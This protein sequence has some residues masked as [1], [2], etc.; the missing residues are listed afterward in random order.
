MSSR[1]H[2]ER[3]WS[4]EQH[5]RA[6]GRGARGAPRFGEQQQREQ[7]EHFGLVGHE[8]REQAREA[9]RLGAEVG[10]D[11]LVAV[12]RGVALVEHE[13]DDREHGAKPAGQL[14]VAG[15]A[16]RNLRV[17]DLLLGAHE[18]LRHRRLGH[19]ERACDVRRLEPAEQPQR[20]RDLRARRERRVTA[21]E[22]EAEAVV[23]HVALRFGA[24][25]ALVEQR[26][27][28]VTVVAGRLA[29]QPVDGAV[30]GGGGD[31]TARVGRHARCPA[32]SR[33]RSRTPPGPSLRRCRCRRRDGPG[34]RRPGRIPHGRSARGRLVAR[35]Q[36]RPARRWRLVLERTDLD[37]AHAGRRALRRPRER[38]VE[39]GQ[40]EDPEAAELFLR[41]SANGPSVMT[42]SPSVGAHDGR[43]ARL[44]QTAAEHPQ[45]LGHELGVERVDLLERLLHH[46]GIVGHRGIRGCATRRGGTASW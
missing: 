4:G 13:V 46:F 5:D 45:A 34:W 22:D 33:S 20:E 23:F 37:R 15:N 3:S 19:E 10:A 7:S 8:L 43:G 26:G 11:E 30:A 27:L 39:V 17:A 32:T 31:P 6:V 1:S 28:G 40:L 35:R 9:D 38:G 44:V 14:G 41:L 16:V 24:L 21:G 12:G 2:A 36:A 25:G 18:A 42:G 29:T